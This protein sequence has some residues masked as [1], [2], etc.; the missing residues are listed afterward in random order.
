MVSV[1][2][3]LA[4]FKYHTGNTAFYNADYVIEKVI[5]KAGRVLEKPETE[6]NTIGVKTIDFPLAI[7]KEWEYTFRTKVRS[8]Q[9][10]LKD[11]LLAMR[12]KVVGCEEIAVKAGKFLA[13]KIGVKQTA[14][15]GK[16]G[17]LTLWWSPVAKQYVKGHYVPSPYWQY[18]GLVDTELAEIELK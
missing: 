6:F 3:G 1:E 10:E 11:Q 17:D 8:P 2:N 12:L 9:R 5:T 7:G 15:S 13:L 4:R 16:S 18:S 14:E